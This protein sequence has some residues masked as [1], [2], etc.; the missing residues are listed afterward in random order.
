MLYDDNIQDIKLR[1]VMI[2]SFKWSFELASINKLL[3]FLY[4]VFVYKNNENLTIEN[5][6]VGKITKTN[7]AVC[8]IKDITNDNLVAEAKYRLNN[9]EID[10][11]FFLNHSSYSGLSQSSQHWNL[12]L[13]MSNEL[14]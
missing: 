7:C 14:P 13:L 8:Y 2:V 4:K 11:L 10:S 6:K 1:L 9:L 5:V 12:V 3:C